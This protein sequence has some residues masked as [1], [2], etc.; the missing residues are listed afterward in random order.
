M[1]PCQNG[2]EGAYITTRRTFIC[3]VAIEVELYPWIVKCIGS[4]KWL[5][6]F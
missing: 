1:S 4:Y 3:V 2:C 5:T 6:P